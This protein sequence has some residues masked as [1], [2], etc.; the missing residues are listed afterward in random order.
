LVNLKSPFFY[1]IWRAKA[2]GLLGGL[3]GFFI[4]E[5]FR[6]GLFSILT[7]SL[8]KYFNGLGLLEAF[9]VLGSLIA[10]AFPFLFGENSISP[11]FRLFL[12]MKAY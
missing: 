4:I 3:I 6:I 9:V 2:D 1:A 10:P 11:R 5:L 8:G 7:A 12:R